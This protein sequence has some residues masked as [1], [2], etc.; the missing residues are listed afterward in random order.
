MTWYLVCFGAG[1]VGGALVRPYIDRAISW[2]K[3]ERKKVAEVVKLVR[4]DVKKL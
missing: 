2:F 1:A 3:G 4:D